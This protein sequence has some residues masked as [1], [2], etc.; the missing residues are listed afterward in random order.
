LDADGD[1]DVESTNEDPDPSAFEA[2][3]RLIVKVHAAGGVVHIW[4]WGDSAR[5]WTCRQLAGGCN[6]E[7]D[8]RLA[9][10]IA[11]R[12]G[13][14]P[15]WSMGYGFDLNEWAYASEEPDRAVEPWVN[16]L[17]A[18]MGWPHLLGGRPEGPN[19]GTDH[20]GDVAWNRNLDYASYE[21]W[22][23]TYDVYVA[24]LEA[25][26][27]GSPLGKPVL[28]E[29]RFRI[30]PGAADPGDKDYVMEQVRR[31]LWISTLAGGVANIWGDLEPSS[32]AGGGSRTFD[33]PEWVRTYAVFWQDAHRNRFHLD[34]ERANQLTAGP[35]GRQY[36][37]ISDRE[38]L[39]VIYAEDA[40]SISLNLSDLSGRDGWGDA[41]LEAV[42]VDTRKSYQEI[43]LGSVSRD[44]QELDLSA[45][46]RSDWAIALERV[47]P[48]PTETLF[49][50][51]DSNSDA[52][53]DVADATF[54]LG[55]LFLA[56]SAPACLDAADANDDGSLDILDP[57]AV[58]L[59]LF[60]GATLPQ[61]LGACGVDP[62]ADGLTCAAYP[63]CA[64]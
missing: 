10:Y 8:R 53:V 36:A 46:G 23:P 20:S 38:H 59:H 2:L 45:H 63:P 31:G 56:D 29:D 55:Y 24:A 28:S 49:R 37:L 19:R 27:D 7:Q 32:A 33:E 54:T 48:P 6:G 51:G 43:D 44:T 12:L 25:G 47:E 1:E 52:T 35:G 40:D 16:Y 60:L 34:S 42:A 57:V 11:A 58:L 22:E 9:R 14:L 30:R 39:L 41:A 18:R 21:H 15:G 26:L 5:G 61:P 4:A 13:P 50:R 17:H 3:E 62:T 64:E